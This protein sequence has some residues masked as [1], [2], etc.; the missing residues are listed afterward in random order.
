MCILQAAISVGVKYQRLTRLSTAVSIS[1]HTTGSV[2]LFR[3][4]NGD[5]SRPLL[6]RSVMW[7]TQSEQVHG[8]GVPR[9][10]LGPQIRR[11]NCGRWGGGRAHFP[12][13][14]GRQAL[15]PKVRYFLTV[16]LTTLSVSSTNV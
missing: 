16:I 5:N 2:Q 6:R 10:L 15:S 9:A 7:F 13:A 11:N 3:L 1:T 14:V 4:Q 8:T 12:H